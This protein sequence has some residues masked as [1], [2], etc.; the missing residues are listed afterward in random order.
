M[1]SVTRSLISQWLSSSCGSDTVISSNAGSWL[2]RLSSS[3]RDVL[4]DGVAQVPRQLNWHYIN[5]LCQDTQRGKQQQ[6]RM[7]RF[8]QV[9]LSEKANSG[10]KMTFTGKSI[11]CDESGRWYFKSHL[12][13]LTFNSVTSYVF[14][15]S[16]IF[17]SNEV[18]VEWNGAGF[19]SKQLCKMTSLWRHV[20]GRFLCIFKEEW[21]VHNIMNAYTT[22]AVMQCVLYSTQESTHLAG[23]HDCKSNSSYS[24]LSHFN[25]KWCLFFPVVRLLNFQLPAWV[26]NNQMQ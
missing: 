8:G 17:P 16:P 22:D 14:P 15:F 12:S 10:N 9:T 19:L 18:R 26:P 24:A 4:P 5:S 2:N 6:C 11:R 23:K 7:Y 21:L 1:S 13:L 25:S 3:G 20:Y